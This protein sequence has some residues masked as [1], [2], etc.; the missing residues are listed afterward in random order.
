MLIAVVARLVEVVHVQL[1]DEGGEIIVLEVSREHSLCEF[2]RLPNHKALAD[3]T[4]ADYI[5]P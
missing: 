2:I 3:F 5:V 1:S 4:P